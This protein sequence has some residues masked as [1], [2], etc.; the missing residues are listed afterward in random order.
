METIA[1]VEKGS[2]LNPTPIMHTPAKPERLFYM[3]WLRVLAFS[4]LI[5]VHS[6]EVFSDW[7]FL[8]NNGETSVTLGYVLKFFGQW[9]M[10]LLFIISGAAVVLSLKKRTASSFL[11]ERFKRIIIPLIAGMFLVIPPQIYFSWLADGYSTSFIDF[12]KSLFEF[13]WYP[14]GNFHWLH[15]WYLAFIFAYT[16][17]ILPLVLA[18]RSDKGKATLD[19]A[20]IFISKPVVLFILPVFMALPYYAVNFIGL[21]GNISQLMYYFP[22]F[23]FGVFFINNPYIRQSFK[24]QKNKSLVFACILTILLY[25]FFWIQDTN[26]NAYLNLGLEYRSNKDALLI[27]T[28]LNQW[29]WLIAIYGY[30]NKYLNRGSK[31][32]TYANQAVFPFYIFHQTV[33]VIIAYYVVQWN[34]SSLAKFSIILLSTIIFMWVLYETVLKRSTITKMMFGIKV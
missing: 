2:V 29:F 18:F 28:S 21:G 7:K 13:Q 26:G 16:V 17:I 9:R 12:Y 23:V 8:I 25:Q 1:I 22:F 6:A 11:N 5:V 33:I 30:A 4:L 15:L 14:K 19:K 31:A 32:L 3:D 34:I 27:L 10:P 24:D 20:S